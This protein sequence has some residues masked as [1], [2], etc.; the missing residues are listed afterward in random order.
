[1]ES[2][3]ALILR[4]CLTLQSLAHYFYLYYA[5]RLEFLEA[6]CAWSSH[7][8]SGVVIFDFFELIEKGGGYFYFSDIYYLLR[9]ETLWFYFNDLRNE[10]VGTTAMIKAAVLSR[11]YLK[12]FYFSRWIVA[13]SQT[14]SPFPS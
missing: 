4:W 11:Y 5:D 6:L 13:A 2:R 10:S 9:I 14:L 12:Y 3:H 8:A 1:M 7:G